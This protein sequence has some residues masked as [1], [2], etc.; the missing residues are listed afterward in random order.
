MA[1]YREPEGKNNLVGDPRIY[2][3]LK[4]DKE[5]L[6]R[7]YGNHKGKA[8]RGLIAG[9]LYADVSCRPLA[10]YDQYAQGGVSWNN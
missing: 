6:R 5:Q 3:Q 10:E 9:S 1:S 8:T 7:K 2:E 4:N